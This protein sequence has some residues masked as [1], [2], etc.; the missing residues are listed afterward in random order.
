MLLVTH[1][2]GH[3]AIFIG[4]GNQCRVSGSCF[5]SINNDLWS[6]YCHIYQMKSLGSYS[7]KGSG[8]NPTQISST[9]CG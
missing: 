4:G 3:I 2:P 5:C 8:D 7:V 6:V 9:V 1:C